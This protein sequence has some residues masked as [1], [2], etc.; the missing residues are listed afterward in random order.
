M[1]RFGEFET[2]RV[3]A[4]S[5]AAAWSLR[6]G[7]VTF[8][9][10]YYSFCILGGKGYWVSVLPCKDYSGKGDSQEGKIGSLPRGFATSLT[11][12]FRFLDVVVGKADNKPAFQPAA[13][14]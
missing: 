12:M 11:L 3:K 8:V 6:R 14:F 7:C 9:R 10:L 4:A 5:S 2:R 13:A 1:G